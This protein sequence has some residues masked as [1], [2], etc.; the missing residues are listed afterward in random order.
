MD[1]VKKNWAKLVIS[2]LAL[3]GVVFTAI[4]LMT[5][6]IKDVSLGEYTNGM[7]CSSLYTLIAQVMF[8]VAILAFTVLRMFESTKKIG[9]Y[10][11]LTLGVG[12][13]VFAI[14]S[15]TSAMTYL[16]YAR[17]QVQAGYTLADTLPSGVEIEAIGGITKEAFVNSL[18]V[19]DYSLTL[20]T[21]TK[22]V[23]MVLFGAL[24]IAYAVK[25]L[26][27]KTKVDSKM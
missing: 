8:F 1:F 10:V 7:Y 18:E 14:L 21:Y 12:A 19:S 15:M 20:G 26:M 2:I 24:P 16:D 9:N 27:K 13:L 23:N 17:A 4:L 5:G 22:I 6:P 25:K 3:V 11:L